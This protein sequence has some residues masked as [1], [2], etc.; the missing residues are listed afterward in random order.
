MAYNI[1]SIRKPGIFEQFSHSFPDFS[2]CFFSE[3]RSTEGCIRAEK[4]TLISTGPPKKEGR[5]AHSVFTTALL[6]SDKFLPHIL[7]ITVHHSLLIE[8][9][10]KITGGR[11]Y[12][13]GCYLPNDASTGREFALEIMEKLHDLIIE[14]KKGGFVLL[15]GDFNCHLTGDTEDGLGPHYYHAYRTAPEVARQLLDSPDQEDPGN[16]TLTT[17]LIAHCHLK[18]VNSHFE[19]PQNRKVTYIDRRRDFQFYPTPEVVDFRFF[20]ELDHVFVSDLAIIKDM[21]VLQGTRIGTTNHFPI[22]TVLQVPV[23]K[24]EK[25]KS[26]R[27]INKTFWAMDEVQAFVKEACTAPITHLREL[28]AYGPDKALVTADPVN[29]SMLDFFSQQTEK[30]QDQEGHPNPDIPPK[31]PIFLYTDGSGE[32]WGGWAFQV[33]CWDGIEERLVYERYGSL[34][35]LSQDARLNLG[36]TS[37]TN[38]LAEA[39][40]IIEGFLFLLFESNIDFSACEGIVLCY[41]SQV[42][43][44]QLFGKQDTSGLPDPYFQYIFRFFSYFCEFS[45]IQLQMLKIKSHM[46]NPHNEAVDKLAALGAKGDQSGPQREI[47]TAEALQLMEQRLQQSERFRESPSGKEIFIFPNDPDSTQVVETIYR[48]FIELCADIEL[49]VAE[50]LPKATP[51]RPYI[52]MECLRLIDAQKAAN[53]AGDAQLALRL[54]RD[55]RRIIQK[56]KR[57]YIKNLAKDDPWI[58]AKYCKPFKATPVRVQNEEGRPLAIQERSETIAQYYQNHQWHRDPFIPALRERP[59]LFEEARELPLGQFTAGELR[60]VRKKLKKGKMPGTD[61]I[62]NDLLRIILDTDVGFDFVL[63]LMNFCWSE[64][65]LPTEWHV[66]RIVA[67]Y[68]QKGDSALPENHRPI[69]LLQTLLKLFTALIDR[70]LRRLDSRIWRMQHGFR[71]GHSIDDANFLLLRL[72]EKCIAYRI[73]MHVLFLDWKKCYDRIHRDR[74]L[75]ALRRFGLPPKYIQIILIIYSDLSFFVQDAWGRSADLPQHEGLRQ[76]DPLACFLLCIIMT[77]IML[78]TRERYFE[79]CT[80]KGLTDMAHWMEREL[81]AHDVCFADDTELFHTNLPNLT[82][83]AR[84]FLE[85]A[86]IYGL[87]ANNE[88]PDLKSKLI[89]INPIGNV[90][91][92]DLDGTPFPVEETA[93]TLGIVYGNGFKTANLMYKKAASTMIFNMNQYKLIWQSDLTVKKKVETYNSLVWSK[94]RW[95]LH[96]LPM[97]KVNR[98]IIDGAQARHLRRITGIPAA[99]I[100][101]ISHKY[102]RKKAKTHRASTDILRAQLRWF[103]HIIR[104]PSDDPL[105]II[106]FGPHQNLGGYIP[107]SGRRRKG[108]PNQDWAQ[109]LFSL[110][111]DLTQMDR[112]IFYETCQDRIKFKKLIERIC[113]L[114]QAQ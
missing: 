69:A 61:N 19:K 114:Y 88:Y 79:E 59:P 60:A 62:S 44:D 75:D 83:L 57:T 113:I 9:Q 42:S 99:Y 108:R 7:K 13:F 70:R 89:A 107:K 84:I 8:V 25:K 14:R 80:E 1:E 10:I 32:E 68:K 76:G 112:S 41:D 85:E 49:N 39:A 97:S 2:L 40:A 30:V 48:E 111:F 109:S 93:K 46:H 3:A 45:C 94:S 43:I 55:L 6:I 52:D 82:I 12:I 26:K 65:V 95:S 22:A 106:L 78:D 51:K 18:H 38:N 35:A 27:F 29:F 20:K 11:L 103:G 28:Y 105:K 34:V 64:Q 87:E 72:I 110:I 86:Y 37:I 74:L 63:R 16:L 81:G 36:I 54:E 73:P 17:A 92:R 96:L 5:E 98:R 101:R 47:S 53:G 24:R 4:Y 58:G 100:S 91:L 104:K 50:F 77:V 90:I 15:V 21:R 33:C 67:I 102:V 71:S 23:Y 56:N 66:A 31:P